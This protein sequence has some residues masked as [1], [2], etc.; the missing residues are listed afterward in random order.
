MSG[1]RV[2]LPFD[3]NTFESVVILSGVEG[4]KNPK[5]YYREIWR[6]LKPGGKSFTFFSSKPLFLSD[7]TDVIKM[8]DTMSDEQKIWIAGSYFH[9]S[10]VGGWENIE[11]WDVTGSTGQEMLTFDTDKD[12]EGDNRLAYAVQ[13]SKI[14]STSFEDSIADIDALSTY[15]K[16]EMLSLK[17]MVGDD[18]R[19]TSIRL[20]SQ[21]FKDDKYVPTTPL[22]AFDKLE[23]IYDIIKNVKEI[24]IPSPVKAMLACNLLDDWDNTPAQ[25]EALSMALGQTPPSEEFWLP[26]AKASMQMQAKDKIYFTVDL[27]A[28]CG[29]AEYADKMKEIPALLSS[30]LD[31]MAERFPNEEVGKLQSFVTDLVI[32]DYLNSDQDADKIL[33]FVKTYPVNALQKMLK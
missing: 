4:M 10:A 17:N 25:R 32:S 11:G 9:Y 29:K 12:K 28:K 2:S 23:Q 33:K 16:N 5:E 21:Y 15:F 13:S 30:A 14:M 18:M 3:K 27:V 1:D 8:W 7:G 24:V 31:S 19:F 20:A 22:P 26:I 6:V